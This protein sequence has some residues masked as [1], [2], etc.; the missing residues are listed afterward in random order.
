VKALWCAVT[1]VAV[2]V[3]YETGMLRGASQRL[4]VD[5]NPYLR[6]AGDAIDVTD[7]RACPDCTRVRLTSMPF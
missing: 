1:A 3:A 6:G 7:R 5:V 4:L 2:W